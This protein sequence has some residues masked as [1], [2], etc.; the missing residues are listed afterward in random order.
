MLNVGHALFALT[1]QY[2]FLYFRTGSFPVARV[3]LDEG[4]VSAGEV[5]IC[6]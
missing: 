4:L 1:P 3:G 6:R 5:Q 2:R